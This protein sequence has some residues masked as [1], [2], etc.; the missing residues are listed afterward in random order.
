LEKLCN[1]KTKLTVYII[2]LKQ[3]KQHNEILDDLK[4]KDTTNINKKQ[5]SPKKLCSKSQNNTLQNQQNQLHCI[6]IE[7]EAQTSILNCYLK[8][9][10]LS[11]RHEHGLKWINR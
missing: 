7:I 1:G 2:F 3:C 6:N 10:Q 8:T 11:R 5:K 4:L 9:T